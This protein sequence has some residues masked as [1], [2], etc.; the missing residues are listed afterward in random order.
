MKKYN[1]KARY[2]VLKTILRVITLGIATTALVI[3]LNNRSDI[4]WLEHEQDNIILK[5]LFN[6]K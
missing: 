3:S 5:V 2:S 1:K 6:E 4:Q